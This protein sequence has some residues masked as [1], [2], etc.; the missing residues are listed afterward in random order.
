MDV[1]PNI[2]L[3]AAYL[4]GEL[5]KEEREAFENRLNSDKAFQEEF[6]LYQD[7][8][9]LL[10]ESASLLL[11]E[12]MQLMEKEEI[13]EAKVKQVNWLPYSAIAAVVLL[14]IVSFFWFDSNQ[15]LNSQQIMGDYFESY[16]AANLRGSAKMEKPFNQGLSAYIGNNYVQAAQG[17]LA[18]TPLESEYM[19]AQLYLGNAYLASG[20]YVAAI[21]PLKRVY[22]SQ[23]SRFA[24]AASWYLLL[25]Y[26]GLNDV[27]SFKKLARNINNTPGHSYQDRLDLLQK[28]WE[29]LEK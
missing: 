13:S 23:D 6:Q 19:E 2:S 10:G 26:V 15:S 8:E 28:K 14:L 24:E 11:K 18:V 5:S 4:E 17:F 12:K 20:N 9:D 1:D 3:I 22:E 25:G 7:T 16:P 21:E 27:D 29:R